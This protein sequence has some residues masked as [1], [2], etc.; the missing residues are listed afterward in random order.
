MNFNQGYSEKLSHKP[1]P[2][3]TVGTCNTRTRLADDKLSH[4]VRRIIILS[5]DSPDIG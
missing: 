1:D 5:E 3:W 4:L 2:R